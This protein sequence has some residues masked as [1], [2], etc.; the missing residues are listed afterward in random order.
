MSKNHRSGAI[1][2]QLLSKASTGSL[3]A[4]KTLQNALQKGDSTPETVP[5]VMK[6][7]QVEDVPSPETRRA[8]PNH[9]KMVIRQGA[10]G[11]KLLEYLLHITHV[12]PSIEKVATPLLVQNVD[13]ICAWIDFLMFAPDADPFW[14]EDQGD[15][16]NLY[17]NILYNAIQTHSS[18]FQVYISSRGFVDLVL[19]LWLREGDKSLITSISNE[20]LGSIPLLT[21]MLGSE[22]ATEALCERAI[23]SGLAGKLTKSLMVKLLQAVRIYINTAPLP[24][25]V[26]Y[27]DKIMKIIVPLTKYN[28]DAMIKAFH[29]NEY[30]TEI[31]TALDILSAAVEKSHPSKLW[32]TT[33]FTV[34]A[35]GINLLFTARTRILQNWGEAIRGDLLGL[36]VRMSAA[37]SNT[38]DLPDM[39]LR[40]YEL[41]RYTLSHLLIHLSYPKV[42]KQLVRC[43]NINAW[44]AGEYSHIRNEKLAN[45]WEIFWK[46][47]AERAV[48]REEIPGATVCD[49]I[50]CD[51][52]KRPKHSW[53]CSRCVTASYCS[54][55][56]Q[57]ED[58]KRFH[59]SECYRAKQ[60][61]IAREMT[62]TRY[63]YSD[64]HFQ[65]SWAQIICNDSLPLFDRD[66]IGRQAFPDH[67]PYEIVPIV[68]CT[69]IL[70]PSTQ[71]FP[72]SLRLNPR[73]WVGTNHANYEVQAS[74]IGPR[75]M[76]LV[77]DFRSGRMWEEY[78]L[79]DFYFLYGS[80]EALSLLMLLKRL[81]GG[82]YKV[83]YSIPRRGVRKT[84]QGTWPI[85]KSDYD[86]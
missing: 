37:V 60:D 83:A 34:L 74:S 73:W 54:P 53:I 33:C 12:T 43:G 67:K 76:A 79:V 48:V 80:A 28:N 13:G 4:L 51:V 44:D 63:R 70:V 11:L 56:C 65:M 30:L 1:T 50:S 22:D 58:W 24:T 32:E 75:V 40:G 77:E 57:A 69:G 29:A 25:V 31:I 17:A 55:R 14:K 15:Q 82:F 52:M 61:E 8:D 42:V 7:L 27:V 6:F 10:Q 21:V 5:V 62:H 19:R 71:V 26:N 41:V 64:R 72:E 16:Y 66:Q 39:Q 18:I 9:S 45:I 86:Q 20:M 78:R 81:P 46:D 35:T 3:S 84:T 49:N 38:K 85:P 23:A 36:L 68:D 2:G 47:A 59:K